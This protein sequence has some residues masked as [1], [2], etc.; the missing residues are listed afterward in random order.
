M[1]CW[2]TKPFWYLIQGAHSSVSILSDW[3]VQ[4]PVH[5]SLQKLLIDSI[6]CTKCCL[7]E[8]VVAKR[9]LS[10]SWY[11]AVFLW[12][13]F[14]TGSMSNL[15]LQSIACNTSEFRYWCS[16]EITVWVSPG[17]GIN[18][19]HKVCCISESLTSWINEV[20]WIFVPKI[21]EPVG[22]GSY[23]FN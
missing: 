8:M 15:R 9:C 10:F 19:M 20:N 2:C 6:I 3:K 17:Q 4:P 22:A 5:K 21:V 11:W 7:I 23:L 1:L 16:D 12:A 13:Q 14:K 18:V